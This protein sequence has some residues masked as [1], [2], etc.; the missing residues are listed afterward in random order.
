MSA[1]PHGW[2]RTWLEKRTRFHPRLRWVR[3]DERLYVILPQSGSSIELSGIEA[4]L[5]E[6]WVEGVAL[7]STLDQAALCHSLSYS[8]SWSLFSRLVVRL[9]L[10]GGFLPW[11]PAAPSHG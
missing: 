2:L 6:L 3:D 4:M 7:G 11:P 8:Q 9:D 10:A 1:I 5:F